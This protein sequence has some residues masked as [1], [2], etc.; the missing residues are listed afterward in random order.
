M[1]Y[2]DLGNMAQDQGRLDDAAGYFRQVPEIWLAYRDRHG[3]ATIY[4]QLG[5][6]MARGRRHAESLDYYLNALPILAEAGDGGHSVG[7]TLHNLAR[8]WRAW[9]DDAVVAR[10]AEVMGQPP[11]DVRAFFERVPAEA[12]EP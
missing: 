1:T 11:D 9:G 6:V 2:Q 3:V 12:A 7:I 5:I 10:T 8:L 4:H